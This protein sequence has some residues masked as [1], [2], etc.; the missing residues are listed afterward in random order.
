M[1][2]CVGDQR[3]EPVGCVQGVDSA[4]LVR[5]AN[6]PGKCA[7]W[8]A[9]ARQLPLP[10]PS[11]DAR[12]R[13]SQGTNRPLCATPTTLLPPTFCGRF[14]DSLAALLA[15]LAGSAR[16]AG[17]AVARMA[18]AD[19]RAGLG[20]RLR[21]GACPALLNTPVDCRAATEKA[22]GAAAAGRRPGKEAKEAGQAAGCVWAAACQKSGSGGGGGQ[23]SGARRSNGEILQR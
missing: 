23:E 8:M 15:V 7:R 18:G 3:R 5:T 2:H 13:P 14:T 4:A 12:P 19:R 22:I 16:A 1:R 17:A 9:P 11:G 20:A 21:C 6:A 10:K